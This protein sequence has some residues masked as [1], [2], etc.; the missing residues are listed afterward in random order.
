MFSKVKYTV[1]QLMKVLSFKISQCW[2][3][4]INYQRNTHI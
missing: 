1:L 4:D 3:T 2:I